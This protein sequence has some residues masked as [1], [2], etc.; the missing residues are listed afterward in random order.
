MSH[1]E[2]KTTRWNA[3][4]ILALSLVVGFPAIC[5]AVG[6]YDAIT[7]MDLTITGASNSSGPLGSKPNDLLISGDARVVDA[8]AIVN[9]NAFAD[10]FADAMV[11]GNDPNHLDFNDG[12]SQQAIATGDATL[13]LASS[14]AFTEGILEINNTSSTESYRVGF[15]TDW[16][17]LVETSITDPLT[18]FPSALSEIR[19][20]STMLGSLFDISVTASTLG[21]EFFSDMSVFPFSVL[22]APGESDVLTLT[23]NA[24][25]IATAGPAP[26]P[27][28]EPSTLAL[29]I[30][31]LIGMAL[32]RR[33][34]TQ[35][36]GELELATVAKKN[37][38]AAKH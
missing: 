35:A 9:G 17:Y 13:G 4:M 27:V 5:H 26:A 10:Q 32:M 37:R 30:I 1:I 6:I 21:G 12:L 34:N 33:R 14:F 38:T 28:P 18:D 8:D 31:G 11:I 16:S 24:A 2:R 25:G 23:A 19:L 7:L 22:L 36:D 20:V 15:E 3:P 29:M